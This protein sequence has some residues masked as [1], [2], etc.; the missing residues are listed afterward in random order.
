MRV[1]LWRKLSI[2]EL[3]LLNCGVGEDQLWSP[4]EKSG[5]IGKDSDA[6]RDWGQEGKGTTEDEM[7]G[8]HHR[9][10]GSTFEWTLRVSD[11]QGGLA[12]CNS[13]GHKKSD[14]TEWLNWTELNWINNLK[15]FLWS[16]TKTKIPLLL[17]WHYKL[18]AG[19]WPNLKLY[20]S[21]VWSS[22][23]NQ[24]NFY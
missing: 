20:S 16:C 7:A 13:W 4:H 19:I 24:K 22:Y 9:R 18:C 21:Y 15:E 6:G 3:M 12:C 1:G 17:R 23:F 11:G 5:L 10:D 14:M 2:E 8:W